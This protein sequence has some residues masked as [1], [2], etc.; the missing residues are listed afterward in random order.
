MP[1]LKKQRSGSERAAQ[2]IDQ[3][4]RMALNDESW[5][6]VMDALSSSPAP[7]EKLK[8]AAGRLQ[9]VDDFIIALFVTRQNITLTDLI[10][11]N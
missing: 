11:A 7:N 3:H 1:L 2:V 9:S 10:A 8:K 6:R 5:A 4:R